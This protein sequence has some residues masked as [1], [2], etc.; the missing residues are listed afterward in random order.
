M[1]CSR[2][3]RVKFRVYSFARGWKQGSVSFGGAGGWGVLRRRPDAQA[4]AGAGGG[5]AGGAARA[6]APAGAPTAQALSARSGTALQVIT[7]YVKQLYA[8]TREL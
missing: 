4:A 5:A 6:V 8:N 2:L 7:V 3:F 1:I